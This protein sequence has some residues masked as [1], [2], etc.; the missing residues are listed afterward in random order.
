VT[1]VPEP[2]LLAMMLAGLGFVGL[3]ARRRA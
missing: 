1:V 2:S 3:M